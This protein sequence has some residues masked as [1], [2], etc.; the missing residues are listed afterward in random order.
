[1]AT[2][3]RALEIMLEAHASQQDKTGQPYALHPIRV[4]G[5]VGS[6]HERMAALLHDVVEDSEWTLERLRE[7]GFP[8][9]V[10]EAVELVT[11]REE[12][13]YEEFVA[14]CATHPV[15]RAVKLADLLDNMDLTRLHEMDDKSVER[16][17]RY[18]KAYRFLTA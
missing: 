16:L 1:M 3:Q 9:P 13:S 6:E 14:R 7:E 15:A 17:R 12:D 4:M 5:R 11:R 18:L 2:V 8:I 10:L